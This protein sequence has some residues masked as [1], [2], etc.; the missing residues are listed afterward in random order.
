MTAGSNVMIDYNEA[1]QKIKYFND[2]LA[3]YGAR[4][5]V[6]FRDYSEIVAISI[7]TEKS[8][9][10]LDATDLQS[11]EREVEKFISEQSPI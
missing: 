8:R 7:G 3:P 10:S 5:R 1:I 4:V 6:E 11:I 9:K 2:K